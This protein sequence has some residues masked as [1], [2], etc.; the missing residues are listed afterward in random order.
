M[1]NLDL[2]IGSD[3]IINNSKVVVLDNWDETVAVNPEKVIRR[4][5]VIFLRFFFSWSQVVKSDEENTIY[6]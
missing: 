3:R 2:N 4:K 5:D 6:L 1:T